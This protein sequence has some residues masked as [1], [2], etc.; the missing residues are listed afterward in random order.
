MP[1]SKLRKNHKEAKLKRNRAKYDE[2]SKKMK[3]YNQAFGQN[4]K[5]VQTTQA[6]HHVDMEFPEGDPLMGEQAVT[7]ILEEIRAMKDAENVITNDKIE[8]V[9]V[10]A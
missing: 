8:T 6:L 3:F 9:S 7:A 5:P 2:M 1:K 10:N 4:K